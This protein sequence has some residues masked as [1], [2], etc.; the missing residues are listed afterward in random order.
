MPKRSRPYRD[1]LLESL[2]DP[3]ESAAYLKAALEDSPEMLLVA[4]KDVADAFQVSQLAKEA[5][6]TRESLYRMLSKS[7]NPRYGSLTAI[8][9]VLGLRISI[10]P[11]TGAKRMDGTHFSLEPSGC[12]DVAANT[13]RGSKL[14]TQRAGAKRSKK[15]S[16]MNPK[17]ERRR[18]H[19]KPPRT[20][21]KGKGP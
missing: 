9:Q 14:M 11:A 17:L 15:R 6:V 12:N 10:E 18:A 5:G 16:S 19:P 2:R 4:L 7:G 13:G 20:A 3:Q 8:L 21:P 1:T